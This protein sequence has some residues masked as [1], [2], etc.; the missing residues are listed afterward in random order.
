MDV[1]GFKQFKNMYGDILAKRAQ[2]GTGILS[3]ADFLVAIEEPFRLTFTP[4]RIK[5]SFQL[6]G[7]HP[8]NPGA[9]TPAMLAPSKVTS[10]HAPLHINESSPIKRLKAVLSDA[11]ELDVPAP[12]LLP[13]TTP[14]TPVAASLTPELEIDHHLDTYTMTSGS[15]GSASN[16]RGILSSTHVHWLTSNAPITSANRFD[17]FVTPPD[18][19]LLP[20]PIPSDPANP[21]TEP[22]LMKLSPDELSAY[23]KSL[24][25]HSRDLAEVLKAQRIQIGLDEMVI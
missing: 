21:A 12:P 11:L 1:L 8:Y 13:L 25:N 17:I 5:R 14:H 4:E 7:L 15:S 24:L 18:A 16:I 9:I 22:D 6:V 20:P 19:S 2:E 10:S 3:K 23:V